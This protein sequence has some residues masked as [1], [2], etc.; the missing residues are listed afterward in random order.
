[1][2]ETL[3]VVCTAHRHCFAVVPASM[4]DRLI[5]QSTST[6]LSGSIVLKLKWSVPSSSAPKTSFVGCRGD[7]TCAEGFIH[8]ALAL[9]E[10]IGLSESALVSVSAVSATT[11]FSSRLLFDSVS[12]RPLS[13]GDWEIVQFNA[14]FVRDHLLEQIDVLNDKD[15]FPLF[16][17]DIRVHL[18]CN[19]A[20]R[21]GFLKLGRDTKIDIKPL[22]RQRTAKD[23]KGTEKTQSQ[24]VEHPSFYEQTETETDEGLC[25]TL[26]AKSV[27][28]PCN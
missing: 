27:M 3:K 21:W 6:S 12:L 28:A 7:E 2:S 9:C 26:S 4:R 1:M 19:M 22:Q 16:I 17:G 15:A 14:E 5:A 8:I 23:T 20:L 13:F 10:C 18:Q 24:N 11:A 25:A